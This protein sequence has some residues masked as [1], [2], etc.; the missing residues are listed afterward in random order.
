[1]HS[2]ERGS[3]VHEPDQKNRG[4]R[5]F[6]REVVGLIVVVF[7][8][9]TCT[10]IMSAKKETGQSQEKTPS[11]SREGP[12]VEALSRVG[13]TVRVPWDEWGTVVSPAVPPVNAPL[14]SSGKNEIDCKVAKGGTLTITELRLG[15]TELVMR[16]EPP[17][18]APEGPPFCKKGTLIKN[19]VYIFLDWKSFEKTIPVTK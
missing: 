1:M 7:V 14:E 2:L 17:R 19:E 11:A 5:T 4:L 12:P 13:E 8:I 3:F 18:D 9:Q 16:Y 15:G 10:M 6:F